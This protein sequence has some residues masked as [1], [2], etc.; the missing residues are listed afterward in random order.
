LSSQ[1]LSRNVRLA[2]VATFV[3]LFAA[4]WSFKS[5]AQQPVGGSAP[6]ANA[7]AEQAFENIQ[8]LKG[9]PANELGTT[10]DFFA[11]S[12]GVRCDFCHARNAAGNGLD[13]ASDAKE[14]KKTARAMIAMQMDLNSRHLAAFGGERISC[15][16]CH[17]GHAGA[18]HLPR[19][20]LAA[21]TTPGGGQGAGQSATGGQPGATGAQPGATG[22]QPP[23][24]GA[25]G[26]GGGQA[27]TG[28]EQQAQQQRPTA[29]QV[30]AKYVAAVGGAD[31]IAKLKTLRMQGTREGGR[32]GPAPYEVTLASPDRLYV[33]A[34]MP[35]QGQQPAGEVRQGINGASGGW[36]T[37]ARGARALNATELADLRNAMRYMMPLKLAEPFP[38]MRV[39]GRARVGDAPAW[40]LEA[41]PSANVRQLFFFDQQSGLLVRQLTIRA[42]FINDV[43]EQVDYEDYR[44]VNGVKMPF[45]VRTSGINPNN[46]IAIR[47]FT[48]IKANVPIED[49][50]FAMPAAPK[51]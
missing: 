41:K 5:N 6:P 11:T 33:V 12:L 25:P 40:V 38:Q 30:L 16:T 29:E 28:G 19:L 8:V 2:V 22:G 49:S 7:P 47:K 18:P 4:S 15:Y 37:N 14:E 31:A 36:T 50:I 26:Q 48:E 32:G 13:F 10:M 20:P 1:N 34:S 44:D 43:P 21:Q 3:C 24:A 46:P 45:T 35:S 9:M 23:A 39:L 17:Q 42:L 27:A 51:P